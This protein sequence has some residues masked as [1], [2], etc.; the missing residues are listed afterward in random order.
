M[1]EMMGSGRRNI[2]QLVNRL[3]A[4]YEKVCGDNSK[5]GFIS[6]RWRSMDYFFCLMVCFSL[7]EMK[8]ILKG[9]GAVFML[10]PICVLG[11]EGYEPVW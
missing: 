1:P 10:L 5:V 7:S 2:L 11:M 8:M 4:T 3:K 9:S 6:K